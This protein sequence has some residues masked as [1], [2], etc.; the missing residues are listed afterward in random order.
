MDGG[1]H[2]VGETMENQITF[3]LKAALQCWRAELEK[4]SSFRKDDLDEL[5]SHVC[6]S[7][8]ALKAQG[9]TDEEAFLIAIRRTGQQEQ[10]AAEF[11]TINGSSVWLERLVWMA[12]GIFGLPALLTPAR[13]LL[14]TESSAGLLVFIDWV[15]GLVPLLMLPLLLV[16]GLRPALLRKRL[17][18][19]LALAAALLL[20]SLTVSRATPATAP[21]M[22]P[23]ALGS[24]MIIGLRF[25]PMRKPLKAVFAL[26]G[27]LLLLVVFG[28]LLWIG[29]A[30][31]V[32]FFPVTFRNGNVIHAVSPHNPMG[33][34]FLESVACETLIILVALKRLRQIKPA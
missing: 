28:V 14:D 26:T 22:L 15:S 32:V 21:A 29:P 11:A 19:L 30:F 4:S 34:F 13:L 2:N 31:E 16:M 1:P 25:T 27:V 9:L 20:L 12:I 6:D 3:D 8:E 10:L 33:N 18:A 5:E 7:A 23:L 17:N 24:A